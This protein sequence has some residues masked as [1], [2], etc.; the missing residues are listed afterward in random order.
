MKSPITAEIETPTLI[1]DDTL[2]AALKIANSV[3]TVV[4]NIRTPIAGAAPDYTPGLE[5]DTQTASVRANGAYLSAN[6][7]GNATVQVGGNS[8]IEVTD[9]ATILAQA[10]AQISDPH[11]LGAVWNN[12]GVL[13][14]SNG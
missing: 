6:S 5:L 2:G 3:G 11:I 13:S 9:S 4:G 1:N 12:A 8:A 10:F 7:G 14:F